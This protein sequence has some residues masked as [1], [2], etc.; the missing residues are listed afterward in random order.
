MRLMIFQPSK[1]A[2]DVLTDFSSKL[3]QA[4]LSLDACQ[5]TLYVPGQSA[6]S[7][8]ALIDQH[9]ITH[10][11]G[12]NGVSMNL[13][14]GKAHED[15]Q[16]FAW[17]VDYPVYHHGRLSSPVPNKLIVSANPQHSH[18]ISAMT[19]SR[20]VGSL[21]LGA[22]YPQ[23]T[24]PKPIHERDFDVVFIGGW[25]GEPEPLWEKSSEPL[26]KQMANEALAILMND[27][28]AD[29][30]LVLEKKFHHYGI[31]L[32]RNRDLMNVLVR[33]LENYLRKYL[34]LKMMRA[35][36][37]SGLKTL[38]VGTGW[39][40][41]FSGDQLYF[42]EPVNNEFIHEI[43]KHCKLAICLNSNN[44]GCER[45]LQA[46][47]SGCVVFSFG[48]GAIEQLALDHKDIRLSA[49]HASEIKIASH[50]QQW[51]E[52]TMARSTLLP[53]PEVAAKSHSWLSVA[54]K[55]MLTMQESEVIN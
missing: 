55:L 17:L 45:A 7:L 9:Q 51:H 30:F 53:E 41:H 36:V 40:E 31:S 2:Y 43:Y 37:Q 18:Y 29:A 24:L 15:I 50:L 14:L 12:F 22:T 3:Y 23:N 54:E 5:T 52:E 16:H 28:N 6:C 4:C 48:G 44:G 11:F 42:H 34:R 1:S 39:S 27:D 38:V 33:Y 35:I 13:S 26:V 25:M 19:D 10:I 8:D 32:E 49:S 47:A 46:L 20:Y 21:S